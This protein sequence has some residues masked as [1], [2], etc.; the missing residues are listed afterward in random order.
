M[1]PKGMRSSSARVDEDVS[2][3]DGDLVDGELL[4]GLATVGRREDLRG[5]VFGDQR[6]LQ[7]AAQRVDA[8]EEEEAIGVGF[9]ALR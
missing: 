1:P 9:R 5:D 3:A 2:A 8:A 6:V 4:V 7:E